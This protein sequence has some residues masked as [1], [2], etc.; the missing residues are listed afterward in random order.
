MGSSVYNRQ[1]QL[2]HDVISSARRW[3][4]GCVA[5]GQTEETLASELQ[6][7]F[8]RV[9]TLEDFGMTALSS[10]AAL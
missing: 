6:K 10:G 7:L 8:R 2:Q 4:R 9:R 3:Y 1:R 5:Q